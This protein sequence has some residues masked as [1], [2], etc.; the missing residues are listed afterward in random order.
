MHICKVHTQTSMR[1]QAVFYVHLY[2][3]VAHAHVHSCVATKGLA[4]RVTYLFRLLVHLSNY[5][6]LLLLGSQAHRPGPWYRSLPP[7]P[8][9]GRTGCA[10]IIYV[11]VSHAGRGDHLFCVGLRPHRRRGWATL[12][13]L[14]DPVPCGSKEDPVSWP[15]GWDTLCLV[16]ELSPSS[17]YV[18]VLERIT[19]LSVVP[20]FH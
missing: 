16:Q 9:S 11:N 12:F 14:A 4:Y 1:M 10:R 8:V 19:T 18:A 7:D 6:I 2:T 17:L 13:S 20:S 5:I 15:C 3:C